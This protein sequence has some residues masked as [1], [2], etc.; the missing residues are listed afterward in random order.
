MSE[1][2]AEIIANRAL[3]VVSLLVI[4]H[5]SFLLVRGILG[6]L[7]EERH[8]KNMK[9]ALETSEE[10]L[11]VVLKEM[12]EN[13]KGMVKEMKAYQEE[14]QISQRTDKEANDR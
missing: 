7:N 6:Y 1:I 4:G 2:I 10:R 3:L 11:Q 9:Q 13:R 8:M 12:E 5:I 14:V